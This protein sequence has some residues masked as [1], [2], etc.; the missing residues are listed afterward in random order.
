M[1]S[2]PFFA[3]IPQEALQ[4]RQYAAKAPMFFRDLGAMGGIFTADLSYSTSLVPTPLHHPLA[5]FPGRAVVAVHCLEYRHSDVGPYNEVS[6]SV[7]IAYGR[8]PILGAAKLAWAALTGSFHAYIVQLP[9]TTHVALVGGIDVFNFPKYLADISF[10][11]TDS[12]RIC[13]V[14]DT[15]THELILKIAGAKIRTC[16]FPQEDLRHLKTLTLNS[17]PCKDGSTLEARVTMNVKKGRM[18]YARRRMELTIG[19]HPQAEMWRKLDIGRQLSY[20][21]AP[22]AEGILF[23]PNPT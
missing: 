17:Y 11:E 4:I 10:E 12:H 7:A 2:S 9:V 15:E 13:T 1:N 3:G 5:I 19:S 16:D 20:V 23:R 22:S 8:K 14:R 21:Y 18:L 6:L